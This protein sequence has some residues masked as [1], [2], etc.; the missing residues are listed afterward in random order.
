MAK[1]LINFSPTFVPG[2]A[3]AGYLDFS[4]YPG[5]KLD[6]LYAVMNVTRNVLMYAPGVSG[7]GVSTVGVDNQGV[8]R[9]SNVL[10]LSLDTS[11]YSTTDLINVFYDTALSSDTFTALGDEANSIMEQ[12]G[13]VQQLQESIK[14]ILVELQIMNYQLQSMGSGLNMTREDLNQLRY[15][16]Q[17]PETQEYTQ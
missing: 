1:Q 8:G 11:S 16:L 4:G 9:N 10:F 3:G 14:A 13:Q 2:T 17:Q 15:D 5:F 7:Y 12:G 6:K